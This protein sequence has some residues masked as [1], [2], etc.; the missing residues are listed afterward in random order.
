MQDPICS[1][2][3][4]E[5]VN[6]VKVGNFSCLYPCSGLIV[7]SFSRSKLKSNL[8][9]LIPM[10]QEYNQYKII[11]QNPKGPGFEGKTNIGASYNNCL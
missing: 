11:T 9:E 10:I 1:S 4:L 7:T 5:C 8:D 6:N 3:E 2:K